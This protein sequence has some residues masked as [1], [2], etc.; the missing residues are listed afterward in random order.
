MKHSFLDI[1]SDRESLLHGIDPRAKIFVF[2]SLIVCAVSTPPD[3]GPVF[4]SYM[5]FLATMLLLSNLPPGFVLKRSLI[6]IPFVAL[7]AIFIPFIPVAHSGSISTG[8]AGLRIY[9]SGIMLVWNIFIKAFIGVVC[10]TLLTSTTP[11]AKLLQGF[12]SI[13]AP[14]IFIITASFM[15]RYLFIIT[16]EALRMKMA[17]DS[18]GFGGRWLWHVGVIGNMI[19]TLFIRSY[20]RAERIYAAMASR[21]FEGDMVYHGRLRARPF[22][23]MFASG[24]AAVL[25]LIRICL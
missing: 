16:D 15:Y 23:V 18:R 8:F 4:L 19:G 13:G 6:I 25:I 21:G 3:N 9:Y 24:T 2:L 20:E 7:M 1:Y 12:G 22:D 14:K 11:F 17:R 10:I 5:T